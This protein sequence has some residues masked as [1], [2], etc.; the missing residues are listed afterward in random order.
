[1]PL[2]I[3][4]SIVYSSLALGLL[5]LGAGAKSWAQQAAPPAKPNCTTPP[6]RNF[7]TASRSSASRNR[8]SDIADDCEHAK[9][10]DFTWFEMQGWVATGSMRRLVPAFGV[11]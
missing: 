4:K 5:I 1:M 2:S 11:A 10:Y 3:N 9:H 8:S 7:S 6:N